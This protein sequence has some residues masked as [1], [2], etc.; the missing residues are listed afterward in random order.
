MV[1]KV[2]AKVDPVQAV[3]PSALDELGEL[4]LRGLV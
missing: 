3:D 2:A 4:G 1:Y